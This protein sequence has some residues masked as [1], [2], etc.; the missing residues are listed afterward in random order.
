VI[1]KWAERV[2]EVVG[3]TERRILAAAPGGREVKMTMQ[4][5]II[6]PLTL[7]KKGRTGGIG[8][9]EIR[10]IINPEWLSGWRRVQARTPV[11]MI[12]ADAR[13]RK[14]GKSGRGKDG[15]RGMGG[16][17]GDT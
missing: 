3:G 7:K 14:G 8:V 17:R 2:K 10:N 15:T 4:S 9:T 1:L 16:V 11:R 12:I 13:T 6:L 5:L